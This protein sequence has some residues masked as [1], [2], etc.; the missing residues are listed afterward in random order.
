MLLSEAY[1]AM[2]FMAKSSIAPGHDVIC[3]CVFFSL[4]AM[5]SY[6]K[7]YNRPWP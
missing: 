6:G 4:T 5:A 3:L 7:V 2:A 1:T